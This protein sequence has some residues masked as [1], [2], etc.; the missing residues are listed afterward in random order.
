MLIFPVFSDLLFLTSSSKDLVLLISSSSVIPRC[1]LRPSATLSTGGGGGAF[2]ASNFFG[3]NGV[4][5][6]PID[7]DNAFPTWT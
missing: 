2:G 3:V 5:D 1:F 7:K 4:N 6:A